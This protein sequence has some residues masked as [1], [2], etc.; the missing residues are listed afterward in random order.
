MT[1]QQEVVNNCEM[2]EKLQ[3]VSKLIY[4]QKSEKCDVHMT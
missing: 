1:D 4:E 2:E 3:M